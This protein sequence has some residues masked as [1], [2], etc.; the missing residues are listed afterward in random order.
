MPIRRELAAIADLETGARVIPSGADLYRQGDICS[1][2]YV[3]LSGRCATAA[4]ARFW[5]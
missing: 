1:T 5:I 3:I 2:Y 4:L